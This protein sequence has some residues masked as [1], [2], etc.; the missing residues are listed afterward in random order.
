M[1]GWSVFHTSAPA[2]KPAHVRYLVRRL[3]RLMP[4]AKFIAGFWMLGEDRDKRDEW[5]K[6]A[7]ADFGATSLA[8]A[9][10]IVVE[11]ALSAQ[12]QRGDTGT[13]VK[14]VS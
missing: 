2:S 5:T 10:A 7:G 3:K 6:A 12:R 14:L 13:P 9:T 8:E 1:P 4:Q 11:Q